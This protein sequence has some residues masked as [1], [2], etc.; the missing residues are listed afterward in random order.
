[1]SNICFIGAGNMAQAIMGGLIKSGTPRSA[2]WATAR[3][4]ANRKQLEADFRVNV[5]EDNV[6]AVE[7]CRIVVLAVKPQMMFGVCEKIAPYTKG[8][9]I[10]SVAAG[11]TCN[12]LSKWLGENT[13]II[14]CMP[15]TPSLIGQGASGLY[16]N[17]HVNTLQR[18]AAQAILEATGKTLWVENEDLMHAVTATSGS[19]PAYFFLFLEAMTDAATAQGLDP[20]TAKELAIQTAIGAAELAKQSSDD[21]ATLRKKVTSPGG[22]TE[23]AILSFE[24]NQLRDSVKQ[25]MDACANRS[26]T[27][28]EELQ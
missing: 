18:Q 5:T 23:Q 12:A 20:A 22:T 4:D 3:S 16:A 6:A 14:R 17:N 2:I 7:A 8:K 11:I 10:I 27:M 26:K 28:A 21:L 19:G 24:Q 25:A 1:M 13:A 15:N 9:L